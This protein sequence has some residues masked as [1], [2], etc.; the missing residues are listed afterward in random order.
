[1]KEDIANQIVTKLKE[2]ANSMP[3]KATVSASQNQGVTMN[4]YMSIIVLHI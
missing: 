3:V 1:M 2:Q 4:L